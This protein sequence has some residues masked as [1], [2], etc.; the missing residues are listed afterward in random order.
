MCYHWKKVKRK[1]QSY[2]SIAHQRWGKDWVLG[3][4]SDILSH[5]EVELHSEI[6]EVYERLWYVVFTQWMIKKCFGSSKW[7]LKDL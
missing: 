2:L 4:D 5:N 1:K 3:S 7:Y 6:N